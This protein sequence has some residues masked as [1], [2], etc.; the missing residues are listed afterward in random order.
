MPTFHT[1]GIVLRVRD[2]GEND[3]RA[4]IYTQDRGKLELFVKSARRIKSKL[5]PHL[6]PM[7][8]VD[9][10]IVRGKIDHLAGIE[11]THRFGGFRDSLHRL[12]HAAWGLEVVDRLVKPDHGDPKIYD[13]LLSWLTFLENL[14]HDVVPSR[15]RL[16]YLMSLYEMLG[17]GP[18]CA[19]CVGCK[20]DSDNWFFSVRDG[21]IL[22]DSCKGKSLGATFAL[23]QTQKKEL[24]LMCVEEPPRFSFDMHRTL[25]PTISDML[26][27]A[28]INEHFDYLP[29]SDFFIR[30]VAQQQSV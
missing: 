7:T 10:Y 11:R 9:C 26:L 29:A 17:H 16:A 13:L 12:G 30:R 24:E 27:T 21:G 1:T 28:L 2:S 25:S 3:R 23:L 8:L 5:S 18:E 22:C 20:N 15:I 14:E 19:R 4:V 6:E